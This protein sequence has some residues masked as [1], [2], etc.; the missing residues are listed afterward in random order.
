MKRKRDDIA[1][2]KVVREIGR[3]MPGV[4]E[5]VKKIRAG[6]GNDLPDWPDWCYIPIAAGIAIVTGGDS[7]KISQATFTRLNPAIITA[8]ASWRVTQGV[9]RF[10][11]DLYNSLIQQPLNG[12]IPCDALK[13]L[14]EW[15]VYIETVPELMPDPDD[16]YIIGF[17]A[18]LEKDQNDG[19]EELRLVFFLE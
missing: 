4:W 9:Y 2:K 6:K 5:D 13:K 12:D 18:H 3:E 16:Q 11:G 19:R 14:P 7:S 17:W 15:C 10:D 1:P 8:A